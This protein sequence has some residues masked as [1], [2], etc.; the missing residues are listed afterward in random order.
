MYTAHTTYLVLSTRYY[1]TINYSFFVVFLLLFWYTRQQ[2]VLLVYV[3]PG[4]VCIWQF[5]IE[6]TVLLLLLLRLAGLLPLLLLAI[7]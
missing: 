5:N 6:Y 3:V 7:G 1:S 2:L 4:I